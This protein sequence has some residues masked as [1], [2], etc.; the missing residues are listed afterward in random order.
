MVPAQSSLDSV[1]WRNEC[2]D[3]NHLPVVDS[4]RMSDPK[5]TASLWSLAIGGDGNLDVA[6]GLN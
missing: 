6:I 2:P 1:E 3:A 4:F 5:S